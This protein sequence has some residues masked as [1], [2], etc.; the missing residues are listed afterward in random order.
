MIG[1]TWAVVEGELSRSDRT[2]SELLA[3]APEQDRGLGGLELRSHVPADVRDVSFP[4]AMRGY[5]RRAVDAYVERVNHLI[6]E[7]E[8]SAR[9]RR[10]RPGR[11]PTGSRPPACCQPRY[12]TST[13]C[14][15]PRCTSS[16]CR[17]RPARYESQPRP[18]SWPPH[19]SARR[20]RRSQPRG[21][22]SHRGR[23]F[24]VRHCVGSSSR[25]TDRAV[26]G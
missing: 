26:A 16:R 11:P 3:S 18:S 13:G 7:L 6:A 9:A 25:L 20:S 15:G 5:S 24:H 4:L 17:S 22:A 23:S 14:A 1:H 12:A 8:V 21:L 19:D 10:S 2:E